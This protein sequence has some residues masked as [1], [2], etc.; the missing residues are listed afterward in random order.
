MTE[1]TQNDKSLLAKVET[2]I[3]NI[4]IARVA[5][6]PE[7]GHRLFSKRTGARVFN[8]LIWVRSCLQAKLQ[9]E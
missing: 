9:R 6:D 7:K 1:E 5:R 4:K 8:R 3:Q 2:M